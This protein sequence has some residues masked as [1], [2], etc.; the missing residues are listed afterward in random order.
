MVKD[1]GAE[2]VEVTRIDATDRLRPVDPSWIEVLAASIADNGL[3]QPIQVMAG[4]NGEAYRLVDGAHRLE[5]AR[6]LGL[7]AIPAVVVKATTKTPD[8]ERRL[9]EIDANLMRFELTPLDRAAFLA[10]RKEVYEAL[11]PEARHGGDR[12]SPARNQTATMAIW[13]FSRDAAEK[14]GLSERSIRR[15]V[16]IWTRLGPEVVGR[17][18]GT[19]VGASGKELE[20]L[21]KLDPET[22]SKAVALISAPE[23]PARSVAQAVKVI[24]GHAE[25]VDAP[26]DTHYRK[27]LTAWMRANGKARSRFLKTLHEMDILDRAANGGQYRI[28]ADD[29]DDT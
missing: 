22:R 1:A 17:L 4:A 23:N 12:R 19:T 7:V 28:P 21:A 5:A 16:R 26:E 13:S 27:L 20:A 14:T 3:Q 18:R 2:I 25:C 10:Q 6:S 24:E 11:H 8:M 9:L 29:E 15:A